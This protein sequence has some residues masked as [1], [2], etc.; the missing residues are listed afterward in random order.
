MRFRISLLTRVLERSSVLGF[1]S[2]TECSG[3]L[4]IAELCEHI[5]NPGKP[6]PPQP[7][8]H[9]S[10]QLREIFAELSRYEEA[11][12]DARS[13]EDAPV[14]PPTS[15][16]I[17]HSDAFTS[18]D[19][20]LYSLKLTL[21]CVICYILYNAI[22]WPGILTCVVTVLFTGLSSTGAMKQKQ[23]YRLAGAAI[24]GALA[25]LV[26]SLLFPN[27]DSVTSLVL[28][29]AA[30]CMASAWISRSPGIGYVGVQIA[31]AFFLTDLPGFGP[32]SQIAPARDRVIGIAL[33]VLVMWFVFDQIWPTRPSDALESIRSRV[34]NNLKLLS[35]QSLSRETLSAMRA[36][37]SS[38]MAQMQNLISSAWFDFSAD[39][40]RELARSR[41]ITRQTEAAAAEFY[42]HL[43]R[44]RQHPSHSG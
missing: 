7:N 39:Q 32:A 38:D 40:H 31:F 5:L 2:T 3:H 24:G 26:E 14:V 11:T 10:T 1:V 16:R 19:A 27:M 34:Q 43:H 20:V 22:A 23:L 13:S 30:V 42:S 17:F 18:P 8:K 37:V 44:L 25:I 4:R 36:E 35:T 33:G 12:D 15:W 21:S 29:A 28:V 6:R 41:R 9:T